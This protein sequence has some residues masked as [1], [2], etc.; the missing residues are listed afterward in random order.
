MKKEVK[1]KEKKEESSS[2]IED[3]EEDELTEENYNN[4]YQDERTD[5]EKEEEAPSYEVQVHH[6]GKVYM[7]M[8][9]A[10]HDFDSTTASRELSTEVP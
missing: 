2:E 8:F 4:K 6:P 5:Y 7:R 10:L 9:T 1:M 3:G